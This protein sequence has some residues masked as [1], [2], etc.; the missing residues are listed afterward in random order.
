M[1]SV[2]TPLC[3]FE[4]GF[5]NSVCHVILFT[6][7]QEKWLPPGRHW[8]HHSEP[9]IVL[10][11]IYGPLS[12]SVPFP[13]FPTPP[14]SCLAILLHLWENIIGCAYTQG[15]GGLFLYKFT[16]EN[17][18][19]TKTQSQQGL[20]DQPVSWIFRDMKTHGFGV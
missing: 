10:Y 20:R 18:E 6:K 14:G 2:T 15:C 13:P 12:P 9:L 7:P 17:K 19:K 8:G 3:G 1:I 11:G 4:T 5:V 16:V